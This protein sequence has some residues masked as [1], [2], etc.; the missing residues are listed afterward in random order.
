M[1]DFRNDHVL[2][3][4]GVCVQPDTTPM[5]VLPYMANGDLLS[6]IRNPEHRP[7][8]RK[9]LCYGID[10][11]LGMDYLSSLKYV[12]RDLAARNVMLDDRL[13]AKVADFGLTRDVYE[14]NYY[15]SNRITEVPI[16]WMAPEC[17]EK[18][19]A[20]SHGDVW[21]Y[22]VLLWE[23]MTRGNQP[24]AL[25]GNHQVLDTVKRGE[26]MPRPD[27]CPLEVY[28]LMLDCWNLR[29]E[30]R[31]PFKQ[32]ADRL[33][34]IIAEKQK[35][36]E[37]NEVEMQPDLLVTYANYPVQQYY[38]SGSI[39]RETKGSV[40]SMST[41]GRSSTGQPIVISDLNA[42]SYANL[43]EQELRKPMLNQS[44][45]YQLSYESEL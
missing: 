25:L 7:T 29:P 36:A 38:N 8:V 42:I 41:F 45:N 6:Y 9:L 5:L 18:G 31:P 20:T 35:A 19:V 10:V 17:I 27:T 26:R 37:P 22:G 34:M 21:S 33:N 2:T 28:E 13:R 43:S 24:Y 15:L 12:H 40:S 4:V 23:L 11:A 44:P 1:K 3:L 39:Q 14:R 30:L 16:K 32:I